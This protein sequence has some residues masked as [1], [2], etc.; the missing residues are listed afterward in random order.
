MPYKASLSD[1]KKIVDENKKEHMKMEF[2]SG[3]L[4]NVL[5]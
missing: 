3:N 2:L 4:M 5:L 1:V